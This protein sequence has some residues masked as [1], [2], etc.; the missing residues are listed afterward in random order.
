MLF[1]SILQ[2]YK[3]RK[4]ELV[5][6]KLSEFCEST[7]NAKFIDRNVPLVTKDGLL[8]C[9]GNVSLFHDPA[10]YTQLGGAFIAKYIMEQIE[11]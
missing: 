1:R 6:N 3:D 11:K 5:N 9:S 7:P 2:N 8:L 4:I 10:H